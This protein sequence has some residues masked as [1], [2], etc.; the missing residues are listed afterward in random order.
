[1]PAPR[2]RP[3]RRRC[4]SASRRARGWARPSARAMPACVRGLGG[5][6][7]RRELGDRDAVGDRLLDVLRRGVVVAGERDAVGL[8]ELDERGGGWARCWLAACA[9]SCV[10]E[11]LQLG[12][13]QRRLAAVVAPGTSRG[14]GTGAGPAC[15]PS[16]T[17]DGRC[18]APTKACVTLDDV[19]ACRSRSA[20]GCRCSAR[21]RPCVAGLV[22]RARE[23]LRGSSSRASRSILAARRAASRTRW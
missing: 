7:R 9:R 14:R 13:G 16:A 21:S 19:A 3:P 23:D 20:D 10:D 5:L 8:G 1:M 12:L 18:A 17:S 15:G 6:E 22:E 2:Q 11:R 4:R